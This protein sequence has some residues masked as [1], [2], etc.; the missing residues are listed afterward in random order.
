MKINLRGAGVGLVAFG[1]LV[2]GF[3]G[4]LYGVSGVQEARSQAVLYQQI[5]LELA[6]QVAPLGPVAEGQ[7]VAVLTIPAIGVRNLV[8]VEGTS[9]ED[10]TQGPGLLRAGPLPGQAGVSEIFGRRATFGAPFAGLSRLRAGDQI[11][12]V[13]GQG[14]AVYRVAA[15]GDSQHQVNDPAPDRLVL[16]TASSPDVPAYYTEVDA[17]LV[18]QAQPGLAPLRVINVAELPL[19]GDGGALWLTVLWAVALVAVWAAGTFAAR[20]WAAWPAYLAAAPVA[21]VVL[22]NLY[23]GLAVLLPN[24]Y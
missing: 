7:P 16:L 4:Y 5:Q 13:T 1:L 21:L 12:A 20:R 18:T 23:Q 9:A 2:L 19:A 24:V 10:L 14:T 8:V 6:N 3:L 15:T 11:Q 17:R 22:W